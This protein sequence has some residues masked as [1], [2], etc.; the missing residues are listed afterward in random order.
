MKYNQFK[1]E[2]RKTVGG[3]ETFA[4][5]YIRMWRQSDYGILIINKY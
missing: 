5:I 1:V 4:T 2:Y 3:I